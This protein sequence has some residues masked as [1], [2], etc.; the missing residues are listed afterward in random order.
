MPRASY[1][2]AA[3]GSIGRTYLVGNDS[4]DFLASGEVIT[5]S[6]DVRI[7]DGI[8]SVTQTVTVTVTGTNDAPVISTPS[9]VPST[10]EDATLTI[11]DFSVAD[12]DSDTLTVTLSSGHGAISLSTVAGLSFTAGDGAADATMT[13][14]GSVADIRAVFERPES[15]GIP[16]SVWF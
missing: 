16:K 12:V 9:A 3:G 10:N 5:L 8:F 2:S 6:F 11:N 4:V 14:T 1:R 15:A 7:N 13:F